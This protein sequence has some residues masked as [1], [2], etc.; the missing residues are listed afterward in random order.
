MLKNDQQPTCTSAACKNQ[1]LT[2]KH[3]PQECPPAAEGTTEKNNNQGNIKTLLATLCEVEKVMRFL[4]DMRY[5]KKYKPN[6]S[7]C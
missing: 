7:N 5:L 4:K 3:C 1:R 6:K 2:I